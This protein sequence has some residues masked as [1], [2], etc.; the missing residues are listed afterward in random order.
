MK[1]RLFLAL[2][3][4]VKTIDDWMEEREEAPYF[5]YSARLLVV[6]VMRVFSGRECCVSNR[7]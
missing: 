3:E 5:A 1:L 2:V 7:E 4:R 6:C